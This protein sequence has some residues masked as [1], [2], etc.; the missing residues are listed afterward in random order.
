[1]GLQPTNEIT[2]MKPRSAYR[3]EVFGRHILARR[4][5]NSVGGQRF[6]KGTPI[7]RVE[8]TRSTGEAFN[9]LIPEVMRLLNSQP[10]PPPT[11]EEQE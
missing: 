1:M 4:S 7:I 6:T 9:L 10:L 3:T 8:S 5:G 11:A 2:S